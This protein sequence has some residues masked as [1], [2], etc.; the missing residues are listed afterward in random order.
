ML[1]RDPLVTEH[2]ILPSMSCRM[3]SGRALLAV[4]VVS[5]LAV[6]CGSAPDDGAA[7]DES[8]APTTETTTSSAEGGGE[9][10]QIC[11]Q[12]DATVGLNDGFDVPGVAGAPRWGMPEGAPAIRRVRRSWSSLDGA[13][14]KQVVDAFIALKNTTA[15]SG[16]LG[17]NRAVYNSFCDELG[18]ET[19]DRNLYDFYVEAHANAF[20][21]MMTAYQDHNNMAHMAPQFVVWHRYLLLRMEADIAE[22]IGDPTFALPYWDWTDCYDDGDPATCGQ[23]FERD[24]L[25]LGG[26][27]DESATAVEGYL[28]EQGFVTHVYTN[29]E[30]SFS[31][32]SIVCAQRPVHRA[33]GCSAYVDGPPDQAAID[34]IFERKVYDADP[35]NSCDSDRDVSF[36]QYL[37]GFSN[38]ETRPYCVATGC[39]MHGRGHGYVG[40]DMDGSSASPNDPIFFLHHAQV[41]RLWAAWQDANLSSGDEGSKVHAGNPGFPDD[42]LGA[43]FNFTEVRASEL[44]DYRALGYEYDSLP[45]PGDG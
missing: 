21:S 39:Y 20:I 17:S 24:F 30:S 35:Y 12:I 43:L 36:R 32:E 40:G 23:I 27:C 38:D 31:P 4:A 15:S 33:V 42:Y 45:T 6:G 19:Y 9:H 14:K 3:I 16:G 10:A 18:L 22:V 5:L 44:L 25:G 41:D 13:E 11:Q 34:G 2:P 37:E 29:G 28:S 8:D 26:S 7:G 1:L